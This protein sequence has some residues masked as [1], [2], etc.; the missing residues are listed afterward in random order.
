MC[1]CDNILFRAD[2]PSATLSCRAGPSSPS[3]RR[4][5]GKTRCVTLFT[6]RLA[7]IEPSRPVPRDFQTCSQVP[8]AAISRARPSS[9]WTHKAALLAT[10]ATRAT[11]STARRCGSSGRLQRSFASRHV[12]LQIT[13]TGPPCRA[14]LPNFCTKDAVARSRFV[15]SVPASAHAN[16]PRTHQH[17]GHRLEVFD[18]CRVVH[19]RCALAAFTIAIRRLTCLL[20]HCRRRH[21]ARGASNGASRHQCDR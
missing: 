12:R 11:E 13:Q 16:V 17:R 7:S 6:V 14:A 5:C 19:K 8:S 2:T 9:Q 21:A 15:S 3:R 1:V 18:L 10:T 4:A 20:L